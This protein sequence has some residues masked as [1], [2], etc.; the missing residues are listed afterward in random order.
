MKILIKTFQGLENILAK[1]IETLGGTEIEILKRAVRFEGDQ[2]LI[3]RANLELRTALRI[4]VPFRSF[5][6]KH[7][8]HFYKKIRETNWSDYFNLDDT[9]AINAVTQSKYMTHSKY[10]ALKAKDA[11]VDQFRD[12]NDG[13]RPSIDTR[14]PTFRLNIHLGQ[15]NVCTLSLDS[16]GEPLHKR[17]YRVSVLEAPINEVLAAGM[18][19][20]SGWDKKSDFIDPMCGSG[21][22]LIEAAMIAYNIPPQINREEFGFKKSPDYD[23]DLWNEVYQNAI[24]KITSFDHQ[25]LGYDKDFHAINVANANIEAAKMEGKISVER[26]QFE[27]M[28]APENKSILMMNPPYDER[29]GIKDVNALYKMIGDQLK[30]HFHGC[31]AWIISS[32]MAA[33]KSVGLAPE[34]KIVLYNGALECKFQKYELYKGT[35]RVNKD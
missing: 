20:L 21:T 29:I 31:E 4:L 23:E 14:N 26:S 7:E 28:E 15:D 17:G 16:S 10:L 22:F 33:L 35:R 9:F 25:I 24:E 13:I 12:Y 3:Y 19:L 6:T 2:K 18:V 1:E 30:K 11:I 27:I 5:K 8:N 32:N 34:K